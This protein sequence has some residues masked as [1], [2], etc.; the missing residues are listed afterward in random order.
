MLSSVRLREL[1]SLAVLVAGL[2]AAR[3]SLADHYG[4]PTGSMEPSVEPGDHVFINKLAYGLRLPLTHRYLLDGQTPRRGEVVVLD[5]PESETV[6]LKRL[7]A[8]P[9]D[10]VEVRAGRLWLDGQPVPVQDDGSH[11][12]ERLDAGPHPLSFSA[13][14]GPDFGPMKLPP[15]R[16]L[17]MGDNRGN[18][19]DGRSFGLVDKGR[20]LGRAVGLYRQKRG[21]RSL[22]ARGPDPRARRARRGG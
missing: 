10:V 18:S 4:V 7:V 16:F 17:V 20:L 14:G 2:L 8:L 13:G 19:H 22:L 15:D 6:L 3:S 11:L 1:V 12:V 21:F 5:S 9:G